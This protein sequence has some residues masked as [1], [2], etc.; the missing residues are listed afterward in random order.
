MFSGENSV[1]ERI[2]NS[3]GSVY[4][5]KRRL[6]VMRLLLKLVSLSWGIVGHLSGVDGVHIDSIFF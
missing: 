3:R 1:E 2:T 4:D 5:I 6:K